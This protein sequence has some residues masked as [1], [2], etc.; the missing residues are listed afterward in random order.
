MHRYAVQMRLHVTH[1]HAHEHV[2]HEHVHA[3]Q[4]IRI[5]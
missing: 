1:E 3:H 2:T 5:Q 4:C